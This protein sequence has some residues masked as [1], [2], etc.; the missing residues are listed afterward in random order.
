MSDSFVYYQKKKA[1]PF[2]N[3]LLQ[4]MCM[5]TLTK[6]RL[7]QLLTDMHIIASI[8]TADNDCLFG[9]FPYAFISGNIEIFRE[10]LQAEDQKDMPV[11]KELRMMLLS[12]VGEDV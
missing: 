5:G 7:Q 1:K 3:R 11:S 2:H 6:A 4:S 9:L 10:K 8:E 12:F